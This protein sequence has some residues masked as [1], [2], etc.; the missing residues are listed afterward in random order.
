MHRSKNKRA[1]FVIMEKKVI[2]C[3]FE[4]RSKCRFLFFFFLTHKKV[5]NVA[6][7]KNSNFVVMKKCIQNSVLMKKYQ[8]FV[9][10]QKKIF[11]LMKK[12][13]IL[14]SYEKISKLCSDETWLI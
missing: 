1:N 5:K 9:P 4:K 6:L 13:S 8:D 2:H 10:M 7:I 3:S 11:V 14:C 12:I